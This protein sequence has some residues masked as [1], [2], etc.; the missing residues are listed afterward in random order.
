[1]TLRYWVVLFVYH[2]EDRAWIELKDYA[3]S[4]GQAHTFFFFKV[5]AF[6]LV[7]CID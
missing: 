3:Y 5:I 1:M 7:L 2:A 6:M 4:V